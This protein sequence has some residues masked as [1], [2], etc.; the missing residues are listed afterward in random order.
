MPLTVGR[1]KNITYKNR[2]MV[3]P[4]QPGIHVN[5]DGTINDYGFDFYIN[6]AR[7]GFSSIT[8]AYEIPRNGGHLGTLCLDEEHMGFVNMHFI[9]RSVHAFDCVSCCEIYHAGC[10]MQPA[11]DRKLMS[12]S[13][14][15]YNGHQIEEMNTDDMAAV[16]QMYYDAAVLAK[17][18]GFDTIMLHFGHG[19]LP[20]NFLTPLINK[21]KDNYGG[22][23]ENRCRYPMELIRRVREAVGD[24]IP[25][26]I[27]MNGWDMEQGGITFADAAEQ[28][29]IFQEA[30]DMIH[31]TC[32]T[33]LNAFER[34][35]M[36]PTS[37]V[38]EAHNLEAAAA[39]KKAGV[40]VPVGIIGSVHRPELA[41]QILAEGKA[42][43][44]L[45]ARQ[46]VADPDYVL[47]IRECREEDIRPCIRCDYCTDGGRRA[48]LTTDVRRAN[49]PTFDKRCTVN[50]AIFQGA[51]RVRRFRFMGKKQVAVI[52][53][54]IAGMQAALAAEQKGHD[55]TLYEAGD[56]L[57]GVTAF[58]TEHQWFKREIKALRNY[59]VTQ[60]MK[61][62][63][64]VRCKC[65]ATPEMISRSGY[66][67][68]IV[69]IGA[70]QVVPPI[71]GVDGNNVRM[72]WDVICDHSKAGRKAIIVG[73]GVV[74]C[75]LGISLAESGR[76]VTII[77]ATS[78]LCATAQ[79]SERMSII[80]LLD[81]HKV[82]SLLDT[83]CVRI[84]PTG[85]MVQN[86]NA[87]QYALEADTVIIAVGAVP[88]TEERNAF[89][90]VAQDVINVGDCKNT[91]TLL[92][93]IDTGWCAGN[94]I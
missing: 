57:G 6:M 13:A 75:E 47:K 28:A 14:F 49:N 1:K 11:P 24:E 68:V 32:G 8:V 92:N 16:A 20:H 21:R 52:G 22:S 33:R 55:V 46:A 19:W 63:V 83:H 64:K 77:E 45:M 80:S 81:E 44:I 71:D 69:A 70:R 60:I 94:V 42:D 3:G 25:I 56:T 50:P 48:A 91:G 18:A 65:K 26:E 15:M 88:L 87:K 17:R 7:G 29:K 9:Q 85:V 86:K 93:A 40:T 82:N 54:G 89:N 62:S 53:G 43:Y 76:E 39:L 41:E 90:D 61:S 4:M 84:T 34:P 73:G 78:F 5:G 72:S 67:A 27:R 30:V 37:F 79:I 35:H 38:P 59:M 74:G 31:V 2:L 10:C 66:D 51:A 58:Y 23:V 12:A 36:H